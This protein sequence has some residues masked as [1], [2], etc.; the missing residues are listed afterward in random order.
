MTITFKYK[1]IKRPNP[2]PTVH[3]PVIPITL[4]GKSETVEV[5]GLLDSGADYSLI[6]REI[7]EVVGMNLKKKPEPIGG[8][9][10]ECN[11]INSNVRIKVQRGHEAYTFFVNAYIIDA[12]DDDFPVLIGRDGFFGQFKITFDESKRNISLKKVNY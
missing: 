10:G 4:V 1:K 12:L 6:P 11:A 5:M 9:G 7:A 2:F 8:I 3:L